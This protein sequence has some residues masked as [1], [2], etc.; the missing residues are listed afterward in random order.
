METRDEYEQRLSEIKENLARVYPF[1]DLIMKDDYSEVEA[2]K[3]KFGLF[4]VQF[5]SNIE[6]ELKKRVIYSKKL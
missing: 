4:D 5:C 3:H 1:T 6:G 2:A